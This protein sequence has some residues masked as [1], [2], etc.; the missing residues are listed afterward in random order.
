MSRPIL[1]RRT[2]EQWRSL[3]GEQAESGLSQRAFC[4]RKRLS[5][6]T[7]TLWKRRLSEAEVLASAQSEDQATWI[8]LGQLASSRSGWDI[9]LDL[10]EGVCLRLRRG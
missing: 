3:I 6:S 9:E 2:A 10:G 7:F 5:L 8:D 1:T 4:K